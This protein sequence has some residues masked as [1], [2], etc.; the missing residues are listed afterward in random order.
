MR[1]ATRP[2]LTAAL[3]VVVALA[4][5][6]GGDDDDEPVSAGAASDAPAGVTVDIAEFAF[7]P[8]GIEI[9]AGATVTFANRDE[10]AHSAEADDGSFDTGDLAAGATSEPIA[11]DEP[12]TYA[13]FCGIHNA[14]T[15]TITV[16]G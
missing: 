4:L 1:T 3:A 5:A 12:G 8:D 7:D 16:T 13:Y 2:C 15:G 14:M 11:F 9:A 10:F 6:A